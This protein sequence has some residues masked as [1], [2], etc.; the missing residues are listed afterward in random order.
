MQFT[1]ATAAAIL[2]FAN[3]AVAYSSTK[4]TF[5]VNHFYGKGP[6]V[7]G[8]MDPIVNPGTRAGH[9][10]TI[11]GGNAFSINL[12]SPDQL[13]KQSTCT[14]SLVKNDLSA[15]W[16]P[17]LYFRAKDGTF[18][19]VELFYMNVYYFF[20]A[21]DDK[22][23]A[24]PPGL[25][26]LVGDSTLR[27]PPATG[28][29]QIIDLADGKPQPVQWTCPRSNDNT[30]LY[31]TDSDGLHGVGIQDPGNKGSGVGFPDKNCDGYASPLRAD[32]HFPSCYNPAAGLTNYKNNMAFPTH[33]N[34]P[35]GWIHV[36]HLFYE[37]YWNT[38]KF[39]DQWTQGQGNQPFVLSNGDPTGYSLHADFVSG[40]DV[41]TLQQII[42]NCDA[43]SSGMDKCPGLIGG[44]NDPSTSCNI[45]PEIKDTIV[46]VMNTLPGNVALGTWGVNAAPATPSKP[47]TS[48]APVAPNPATSAAPAQSSTAPVNTPTSPEAPVE[49]EKPGATQPSSSP[50]GGVF[51]PKPSNTAVTTVA[52]AV[53]APTHAPIGGGSNTLVTSY[54]SE[55]TVVWTTVTAPLP[56]ATASGDSVST[57]GWSY[58]GCFSDSNDRVLSGIKFAN[59]GHRQV[60]NTKC[61][62]Y[63]D[64]KGF[65]MAGT[66]YGG[67]CF[68]GNALSGST[69]VE[70]S[71]C[72][73]PCEGDNKETC[74]GSLTLSVYS[75][76]PNAKRSLSGRHIH[77]HL[78]RLSQ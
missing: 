56:A 50:V 35:Q 27:T 31:P 57:A 40:W 73:M 8:A 15:Y 58:H 5:A 77:K 62:A 28:G 9:V 44:L 34:C 3:A 52:N 61:V 36:P 76:A 74:G 60:T 68:C 75:K 14:S 2:A 71:K 37:L 32:I 13:L 24:F 78:R 55:T 18:K 72:N 65:S 42:D 39:A 64:S 12:S 11:Q 7:E 51:V 63:C 54:V 19:D 30:P 33:G 1:F 6:L 43:G 41:A 69:S 20:D 45:E 53:P 47:Q 59:I 21:T 4:R 48:A 67:Q 49:S 16:A 26:M 70:E 46:G 17:K 23:Q 10:H 29:R 38:P 22:I 66:E 25:Q